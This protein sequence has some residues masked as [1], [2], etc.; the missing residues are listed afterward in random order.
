MPKA[1]ESFHAEQ[2]TAA[3]VLDDATEPILRRDKPYRRREWVHSKLFWVMFGLTIHLPRVFGF[4]LSMG[5]HILWYTLWSLCVLR[6]SWY[7]L[8]PSYA[9]YVSGQHFLVYAYY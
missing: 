6:F 9:Y 7:T 8:P 2:A 4:I 3:L 1:S 5:L